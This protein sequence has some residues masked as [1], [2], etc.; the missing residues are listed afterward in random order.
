MTRI[1]TRNRVSIEHGAVQQSFSR[2]VSHGQDRC[3][4]HPDSAT[5]DHAARR[6]GDRISVIYC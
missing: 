3:A 4:Q 1:L 5:V 6:S 2:T